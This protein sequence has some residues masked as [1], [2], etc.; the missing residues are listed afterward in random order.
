MCYRYS[1]GLQK[2]KEFQETWGKTDIY[3]DKERFSHVQDKL[4][5]QVENAQLWY[6][7]CLLYFQQYSRMPFP[8]DIPL[9]KHKL[10]DLV[11]ADGEP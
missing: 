11:Y 10:E 4:M 9:I 8:D 1:A 5:E 7:A 2:V 3:V 6:D